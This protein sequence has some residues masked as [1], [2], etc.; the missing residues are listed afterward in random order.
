ALVIVFANLLSNFSVEI[1]NKISLDTLYFCR[2]I[3]ATLLQQSDFV[4]N[5]YIKKL[6]DMCDQ[7]I[8]KRFEIIAT[9]AERNIA[10]SFGMNHE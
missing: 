2:L 3:C 10:A 5:E 4:D 8:T 7:I 1:L 6:L 9:V